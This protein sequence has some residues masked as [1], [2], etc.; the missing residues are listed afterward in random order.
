MVFLALLFATIYGTTFLTL[1]NH[2]N[3]QQQSNPA[4]IPACLCKFLGNAHAF[5]G[6]GHH[7]HKPKWYIMGMEKSLNAIFQLQDHAFIQCIFHFGRPAGLQ[8]TLQRRLHTT[9]YCQQRDFGT[10][11][12][13]GT[14]LGYLFG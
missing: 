14:P 11:N 13:D 2:M 3:P 9:L 6:H 1:N 8:P 12:T 4:W 7:S 10:F 5:T